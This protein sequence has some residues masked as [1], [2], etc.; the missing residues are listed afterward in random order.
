MP[1]LV[2]RRLAFVHYIVQLAAECGPLQTLDRRVEKAS[3]VIVVIEAVALYIVTSSS[4]FDR[5]RKY[6]VAHVVCIIRG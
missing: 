5:G 6:R 3:A 1:R 4:A 2:L